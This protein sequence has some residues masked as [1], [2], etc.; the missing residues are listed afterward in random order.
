MEIAGTKVIQW[1]NELRSRFHLYLYAQNRKSN[2][3]K[4][5]YIK[6]IYVFIYIYHIYIYK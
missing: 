1:F 4:N 5:I 6:I 2:I 3:K